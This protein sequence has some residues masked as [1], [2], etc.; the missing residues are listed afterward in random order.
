MQKPDVCAEIWDPV[1]GCDNR[2]YSNA[3]FAAMAGKNV[4]YEGEC[5]SKCSN[6]TECGADEYCQK[7]GC[8]GQGNCTVMPEICLAIYEPV[9][10]CDNTTYSNA[11]MAALSGI[12]VDY[13][14]ECT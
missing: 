7:D 3:C 6:N 13:E 9:C 14:G 1:C 10:G 4:D 2:T 11:C 12:N 8:I 5:V